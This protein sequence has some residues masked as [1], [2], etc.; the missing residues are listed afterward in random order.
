MAVTSL[1]RHIKKLS[2]C[3]STFTVFCGPNRTRSKCGKVI[4]DGQRYRALNIIGLLY[5]LK[6]CQNFIAFEMLVK[7]FYLLLLCHG[8]ELINS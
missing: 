4:V 1:N 8:L 7:L 2:A 5:R 6:K 3:L